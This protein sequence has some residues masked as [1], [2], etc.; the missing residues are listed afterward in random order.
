MTIGGGK[1]RQGREGGRGIETEPEIEGWGRE[2]FCMEA[3]LREAP[4]EGGVNR[5]S[6]KGSRGGS[7]A[8]VPM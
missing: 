6:D 2:G 3:G 8:A 4:L 1:G 5:N 7:G